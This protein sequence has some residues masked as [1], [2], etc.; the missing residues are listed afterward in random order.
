MERTEN[1]E[2]RPIVGA[3]PDDRRDDVEQ[4]N[5]Q[6]SSKTAP[7]Q[8]VPDPQYPSGGKFWLALAS[9]CLGIFLITLDSTIIA[10]AIPYITDEFK[11]L[12]DVG[13][14]GSI[15]LMA[16]CMSQ[17]LFGKL[18]ARYAA[19]WI[20]T[21]AMLIFLVGSAI[22]GAAPS[23]PALIAG[24]AIAGL[25]SSG[26][27]I[28]AYSL[29]PTLT[30]PDKRAL[31]LS[32]ISMSRSMAATAGPLVGGALTQE[33]SWRWTFYIN[34]PIGAVIY[35]VFM[36]TVTPPP[37]ASQ[38]FTSFSDFLRTLDPLGLGALAPAVV[39]LLL[40]L[41]WGGITY[42]WSDG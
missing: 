33:A 11:S 40:A 32:L 2:M 21:A 13:W 22:C 39:C 41:Q 1:V 8:T 5:R 30:P 16:L 14:Y 18:S 15:Y 23:S 24:R 3:A 4:H 31:S 26:L 20:Y 42:A 10:T 17:L 34:L 12:D 27:L 29:V 6:T 9:V 7:G 38:S 25:G 35:A 36:L 19:R 37:N 28:V